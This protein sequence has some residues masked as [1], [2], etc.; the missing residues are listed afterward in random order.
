[1]PAVS[2]GLILTYSVTQFVRQ[3]IFLALLF[4]SA[5]TEAGIINNLDWSLRPK[6]WYWYSVI[7][8]GSN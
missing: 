7:I 6:Y 5:F 1:V 3:H 2:S 8:F 4:G